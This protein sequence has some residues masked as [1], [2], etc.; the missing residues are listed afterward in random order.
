MKFT[1]EK[2]CQNF[3]GDDVPSFGTAIFHSNDHSATNIPEQLRKQKRQSAGNVDV[4]NQFINGLLSKARPSYGSRSRDSSVNRAGRS[5]VRHQQFDEVPRYVTSPAE[6]T[7][8][9]QQE[10]RDVTQLLGQT[11][12]GFL[13]AGDTSRPATGGTTR[14]QQ[15]LSERL[16]LDNRN[17]DMVPAISQGKGY[18]SEGL[19][20]P[21]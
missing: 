11:R 14:K 2:G 18:S 10:I 15:F 20:L 9:S 7:S 16:D 3:H 6:A 12:V 13:A 21:I 19:F 8:I 17:L 1:S 5:G 4:N